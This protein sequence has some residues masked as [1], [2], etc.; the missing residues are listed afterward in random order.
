MNRP[1]DEPAVN[2]DDYEN[3]AEKVD[4]ELEIV[5]TNSGPSDSTASP[6]NLNLK[7]KWKA[8]L[9]LQYAISA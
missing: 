4:P 5:Q 1:A 3:D 8:Q 6:I 7:Q 2:Q 9:Y